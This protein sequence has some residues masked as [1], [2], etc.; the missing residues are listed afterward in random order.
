MM[1]SFSSGCC[2]VTQSL[3]LH[4]EFCVC[5]EEFFYTRVYTR[6]HVFPFLINLGRNSLAREFMLPHVAG[7]EAEQLRSKISFSRII[8]KLCSRN[9]LN[10]CNAICGMP[11]IIVSPL[12]LCGVSAT[13]LVTP[14]Y[15]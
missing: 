4:N 11:I 15:I 14:S 12:C 10:S 2:K 7:G 6:V 9:A 1:G 13:V 8:T 5:F 3:I